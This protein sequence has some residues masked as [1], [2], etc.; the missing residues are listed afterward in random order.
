[1]NRVSA[2]G[3]DLFKLIV[4][5][6]LALILV[7]L[8]LRGCNP[9]PPAPVT[10]T[11]TPA[12]PA[13]PA[14]I[15]G[16]DTPGQPA[17]EAPA[18]VPTAQ[19]TAVTPTFTPTLVP[20]VISPT[21]TVTASLEEPPAAITDTPTPTPAPVPPSSS[22]NTSMPS[23]LSVGQTARTLANLNM[24]T[25][26]DIKAS[27]IQTNRAGT[28]VDIIGGPQ[29]NPQGERAYL[30]WQVRLANGQEGWSA[31]TPLIQKSYFLEPVP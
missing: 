18:L 3:Y 24:R 23:R 4:A 22:C 7:I 16:T 26:P 25:G 28:Q 29:C 19:E 20:T 30:W 21:P 8:L 10:G 2:P 27:L 9:V 15:A 14:V 12:N 17:T 1:M 6:I 31:E 11:D 13:P 5:L